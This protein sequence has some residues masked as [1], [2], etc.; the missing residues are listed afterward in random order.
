MKPQT[1]R[2]GFTLVELLVVIAIIG[3]LVG[4]LLPAVQAAREA[5]RRMQCSNN[6]KQIGLALHNYH[7]SF[8][9]FPM[10]AGGTTP[11][12]PVSNVSMLSYLVPLLPYI[13]QQPLWDQIN[14]TYTSSNGTTYPPMGPAPWDT[15]YDPWRTTV[16]TFRCPSDPAMAMPGEFGI[17]NYSACL[18]DGINW[19]DRGGVSDD[20][21]HT[22]GAAAMHLRGV[23]KSR[24][25]TRMRDILDGTSNTIMVGE[26]VA[27]NGNREIIAQP[28]FVSGSPMFFNPAA[29][30]CLSL[31]DS[32]RPQFW[33]PS[34]NLE[35]GHND[36]WERGHRWM[37]GLPMYTGFNTCRP[38]NSESCQSNN[39]DGREGTVTAASRHPGGCHVVMADGSVKYITESIDAGDQN[40]G[41]D[42]AGMKSPYGVWGGLGTAARG[43][44]VQLP[45]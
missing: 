9:R 33:L 31:I 10:Q 19:T 28:A 27:D 42:V 3:V 23:F 4:L 39:S 14:S 25:V 24:R 13:E 16:G 5:A 2:Q 26:I 44:T 17:N 38:P 22:E 35:Y 7:T 36:L 34:A 1:K 30:E 15:G 29:Q 18:G 41:I 45:D 6:I 40:A 43:E 37:C 21:K 12:A 8:Q 32:E 20:R 11:P